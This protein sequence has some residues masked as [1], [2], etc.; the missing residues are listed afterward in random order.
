MDMLTPMIIYQLLLSLI[1]QEMWEYWE[2]KNWN[3]VFHPDEVCTTLLTCLQHSDNVAKASYLHTFV[4]ID[5]GAYLGWI[6]FVKV[7]Y[8]DDLSM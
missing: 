8:Q 1:H 6:I 7:E 4:V 5:R 3:I 2:M